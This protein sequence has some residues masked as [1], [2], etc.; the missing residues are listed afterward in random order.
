MKISKLIELLQDQDSTVDIYIGHI[1]RINGHDVP[2]FDN[3]TIWL[4][5]AGNIMLTPKGWK[6]QRMLEA[7]N[8][9]IRID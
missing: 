9:S 7:K 2:Q 8:G 4:D 6:V 3:F 1:Y 5:Y